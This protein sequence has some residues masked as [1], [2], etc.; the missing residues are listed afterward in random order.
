MDWSQFIDALGGGPMAVVAI[1]L[2]FAFWRERGRNDALTDKL[3]NVSMATKDA[4]NELTRALERK[5]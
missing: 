2:A 3:F 4:L 1:A 5:P